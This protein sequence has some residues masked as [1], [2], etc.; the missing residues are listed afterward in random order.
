MPLAHE[1][2]QIKLDYPRTY[3]ASRGLRAFYIVFGGF[4]AIPC[5]LGLGVL[6]YSVL[7][8]RSKISEVG[9]GLAICFGFA[10]VGIHMLLGALRAK[11]VLFED[12]IEIQKA[13]RRHVLLRADIAG[14]RLEAHTVKGRTHHNIALVPRQADT[15]AIELDN[16]FKTDSFFKEWL[17]SLPDLD[18]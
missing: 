16:N 14:R 15:A 4:L 3:R 17:N 6:L 9:A 1:D 18:A 7:G 11:V 13:M 8:G 2:G 12:R 10:L 5:V